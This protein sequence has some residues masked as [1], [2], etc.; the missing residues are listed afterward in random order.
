MTQA[1]HNRLLHEI[2]CLIHIA[3]ERDREGPQVG[4]GFEQAGTE[5]V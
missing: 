3:R 4:D 5:F 1:P 2:V